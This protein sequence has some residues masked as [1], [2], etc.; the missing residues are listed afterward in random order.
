MRTLICLYHLT[1]VYG[2]DNSGREAR[3]ID[4]GTTQVKEITKAI[5]GTLKNHGV[6]RAALF[7]SVARGEAGMRS[8]I[9]LLVQFAG[10][11]SLLDLAGLKLELQEVTGRKVDVLTF[12]SLHPLLRDRIMKERVE[13]L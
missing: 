6:K 10:N 9:D 11:K 7:G 1:E 13:I 4:M 12:A 8:D 3:F 2:I 5:S